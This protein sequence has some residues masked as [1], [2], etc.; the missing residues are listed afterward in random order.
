[1]LLEANPIDLWR[2]LNIN[3]LQQ[4]IFEGN[5]PMHESM[6]DSRASRLPA[7]PRPTRPPAK[8]CRIPPRGLQALR[9]K[10]PSTTVR[11]FSK[12]MA[13][14][15]A[16]TVPATCAWRVP[17]RAPRSTSRHPPLPQSRETR[18]WRSA[19]A[20]LASSCRLSINALKPAEPAPKSC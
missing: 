11:N 3:I 16:S 19:T 2:D 8:S 20:A 14:S 12:S 18:A 9:A 7:S 10:R 5:S 17:T 13:S 1:M 15:C 4:A 6:T